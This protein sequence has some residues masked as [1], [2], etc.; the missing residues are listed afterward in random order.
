MSFLLTF[1]EGVVSFVSPC[2]LPLLPL[3]VTY[4]AAGDGQAK[5]ARTAV[6]A[7]AFVCGFTLMFVALGV[8]AGSL[9]AALAAHRTAVNVVCGVLVIVFGLGYLGLFRLPFAGVKGT[10][11][12]DGVVPAFLFGFVYSVNLTPCV[13]AFLGSALMQAASEGGA[14]RGALLLLAYSCGLGVP[15]VLSAVLLGRFGAAFGFIKRHYN[16]IN[17]VCGALLVLFGVWMIVGAW[18][19]PGA[20]SPTA[21]APAVVETPEAAKTPEAAAEV[22]VTGANFEAEV[23]KADKPV[24]VDFWAPWCGP[25]RRLGPLVAELAREKAGVLKVCKVNVDDAQDLAARFGISGIPTLILFK[26][27]KAVA[28]S[29]GLLD[30]P[31][32]E[33]FAAA[34][35]RDAD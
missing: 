21:E 26:D 7:A 3:Y 13:G 6:R 30:K 31:A 19:R 15:F 8:F 24:L 23:L 29:V 16:V 28:T 10:H 2:M 32:L 14:A 25:C 4:F 34:G 33:K 5:T 11:R 18:L 12:L 9:G 17:P 22:T 1:L 27:G 35:G 20:E